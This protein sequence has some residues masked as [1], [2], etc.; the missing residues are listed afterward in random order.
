MTD[1]SASRWLVT[2]QWLSGQLGAPNVR[3]V[4]GSFYLP[5]MK[6]DPAAEY[7]AAHIPGAVRFDIDEISDKSS[8]LPH[9]LPSRAEFSAS[10]REAWHLG[11]RYDRRL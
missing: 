3:V 7:L 4:D 2:P 10:G 8:P 6:R 1:Q 11:A 5:A 9:M